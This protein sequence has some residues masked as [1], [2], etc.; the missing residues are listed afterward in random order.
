[1][2]GSE[3]C[4]LTSFTEL[5]LV[6]QC[7]CTIMLT[8]QHSYDFEFTFLCVCVCVLP[9]GYCV[10]CAIYEQQIMCENPLLAEY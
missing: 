6:C 7:T 5:L 9:H 10:L 3:S 1:M 8:G 4:I 2:L